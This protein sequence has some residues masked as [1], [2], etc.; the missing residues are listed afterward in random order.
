MRPED[1]GFGSGKKCSN[2][3]APEQRAARLR[4]VAKLLMARIAAVLLGTLLALIAGEALLRA[5]R[6]ELFAPGPS[7]A[8]EFIRFDP[9]L[10]WSNRPGAS[11]RMRFRPDFDTGMQISRQG[12]RDRTFAVPKPTGVRRVLCLGDSFTWGMGVEESETWPKVLERELGKG[13]EAVNAGVNG[14]GTAQEWLWLRDRGA[15]FEPDA[16]VL[17]LY[18]NDFSDNASDAAG[19]WFRPY[20]VLEGNGVSLR[21]TPVPDP[22][23]FLSRSARAT[24]ENHSWLFRVLLWGQ[25]WVRTG[26]L[27]P[28]DLSPLRRRRTH[29]PDRAVPGGAVT[30]ATVRLIQRHCA[31][32][33]VRFNVLLVPSRWMVRPALRG[34]GRGPVDELLYSTAVGLCARAGVETIDPRTAL[35]RSEERDEPVYHGMDMHWNARGQA[36]VGRL[37]AE[38]LSRAPE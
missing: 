13:F 23:G 26:L 14:W 24:L 21:G 22:S 16:V 35:S 17:A 9:L 18:V 28:V 38:T 12:L 32:R 31:D 27:E 1:V 25:E 34:L 2:G 29:Q 7:D 4:A 36:L 20:F 15:I 33:G 37:V 8:A 10:G 6:P 19:P 5:I 30:E 11:G 3:N